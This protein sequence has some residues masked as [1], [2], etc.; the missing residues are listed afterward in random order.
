[1]GIMPMPPPSV[2]PAA[3]AGF[4]GAA[5]VVGVAFGV[6]VSDAG[7]TAPL[8]LLAGLIGLPPPPTAA[9]TATFTGTGQRFGQR[10]RIERAGGLLRSVTAELADLL[11]KLL[12]HLPH[13]LQRVGLA[14]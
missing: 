3:A 14:N 7:C 2:P 8:R 10:G 1:M 5:A 12:G 9:A 6:P 13:G 11:A 4:I